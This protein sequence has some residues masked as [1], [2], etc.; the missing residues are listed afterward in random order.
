MERVSVRP[1]PSSRLELPELHR[2]LFDPR[3]RQLLLEHVEAM[4]S[5][6]TAPYAEDGPLERV[7]DFARGRAGF[8]LEQDAHANLILSWNGSGEAGT[9]PALAFSA[10][11]DHPGFHY[12]GREHGTHRASFHGGVPLD[13]FPGAALRF[14]DTATREARATARVRSAQREADGAVVA[15]LEDLAGEACPGLFGT[16]DLTPGELRGGRLLS[17]ACDDLVGAAAILCALEL[18]AREGHPGR[19]L[20]IFTRAEETG[21]VGCQSLLRSGALGSGICVVGLECS[22]ARASARVGGGPVIRVGDAA[23]VFDPAITHHLQEA[24]ATLREEHEGFCFQ[25]ALMDGGRCESTAYNLWG[26]RAG[27]LCLALGNYHNCG[28]DGAIA[29]EIVDWDDCEGL[30]ALLVACAR[31]W[32]RTDAEARMRERLDRVWE[33]ESKSL[34]GSTARLLGAKAERA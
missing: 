33:R 29:P 13:R 14:F 17:R 6:P 21:F 1:A 10:H 22:A 2:D 28:E 18:L 32:G 20:G 26:V 27:G 31:S 7:R 30:L 15:K 19:I 4:L 3:E 23:S 24:A 11:L 9:A 12:L 16:W 5:Q 25:R 8:T 34:A